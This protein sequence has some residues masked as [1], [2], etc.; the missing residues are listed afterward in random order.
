MTTLEIR[1]DGTYEF[2]NVPR[3][4]L[5]VSGFGGRVSWGDLV[6]AG[7]T[8]AIARSD[9]DIYPMVELNFG[10]GSESGVGTGFLHC[11]GS[12]EEL[13]LYLVLSSDPDEFFYFDRA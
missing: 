4:V 9:L 2:R 3:Q 7:G 5:Q 6:S 13:R 10:S 8:W 12:G 11:R 1:R